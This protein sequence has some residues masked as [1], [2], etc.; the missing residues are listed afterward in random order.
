MDIILFTANVTGAMLLDTLKTGSLRPHV[1]TYSKGF[2]R[3][4]LAD[5]FTRFTNDFPIT[6]ISANSHEK[7]PELEQ[8]MKG[9]IA[10]C[11]D[12]TKDF[13]AGAGYPVIYSHPSLL[14]L[15]RGYSAVTE[16]FERGVAVSGAT[17]YLMSEQIDGGDIIYQQKIRLDFN[18]YPMDFYQKYIPVCAEFIHE[19]NMRGPEGFGRTPQNP[20]SAVYLQRKRTRD[21]LIDFNRDAFSLYNHI[22]AYSRPFFG[23][24]FLMNGQKA[25]VW[26]AS[27]EKWQGDYGEPG[28]IID[29][30]DKQ[31]EVA[32]GSGTI[33]LTDCDGINADNL[34][35]GCQFA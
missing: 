12:W 15:Y 25:T 21:A 9:N 30:Y 17:F 11:V 5:D 16:Q 27:T 10:V 4:G 31:I 32:C 33:M 7:C 8:I 23:A 19:L 13:F 1:I 22:R 6:F 3:T 26:R 28:T 34:S 35:I 24:Y 29:I 14:P 18:D 20:D 2:Q